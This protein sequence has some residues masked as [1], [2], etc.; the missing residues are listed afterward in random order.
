[1][2]EIVPSG[3]IGRYTPAKNPPYLSSG[4]HHMTFHADILRETRIMDSRKEDLLRAIDF[5]ERCFTAWEESGR[6]TPPQD[7]AIQ[8]HYLEWREALEKG[9]ANVK[10]LPAERPDESKTSPIREWRYRYFLSREVQKHVAAGRLGLR[11]GDQCMSE[12]AARIRALKATLQGSGLWQGVAK[13][14]NE[15]RQRAKAEEA[16]AEA[17]A[18][19]KPTPPPI[20]KKI[21]EPKEPR[22]SPLEVLL[23]PKSTQYLMMLGGGLAVLGLVIWL[24]VAGILENPLVASALMGVANLAV[25]GGGAAL[26]L[27]TRYQT[28][29]RG[30]T[31]LACLVLPLHLWFYSAQDLIPLSDGGP[32]WIPA[33][34]IC[35]LYA[36]TAYVVKDSSFVYVF[37]GG[38]T[39]T[40]L[41]ILADENVSRFGEVTAPA[42]LL[43]VIALA[44][45]HAER[46]FAP[47][48]GP[49]SREKFGSAF[50]YAGHA[51]LGAALMLLAGSQIAGWL[52][53][54][55]FVHL[56][57]FPEPAVMTELTFK[58]AFLGTVAA[59]T[60]A[61]IYSDL[62]V[63]RHHGFAY[64]AV[65]TLLWCEVLLVDILPIPLTEEVVIMILAITAL[66]A[67]G[68]LGLIIRDKKEEADS[69]AGL[70]EGW[71]VRMSQIASSLGLLLAV[72]PVSL[73]ILMYLRATFT[74]INEAWPNGPHE[75]GW[76]YVIAMALTAVSCRVGAQV[77]RYRQE[78]LTAVYFFGTAAATLMM[79]VGLFA[80]CGV[81][82]WDV[83]VPVLMLIPIAYLIAAKFWGE[84]IR[85]PLRRTAHIATGVMLAIVIGA[86]LNLTPDRRFAPIM[87][88]G[89]NLLV[90]LFFAEAVVFYVIAAMQSKRPVNAYMA[91]ICGAASIWQLLLYVNAPDVGYVATFAAIGL[92][93]LIAYRMA[94]TE[95]FAGANASLTAFRCGN[96]LLTC[97]GIGG[98][99]L[100]LGRFPSD[101]VDGTL[102]G[103][104]AFLTV[105]SVSAIFLVAHEGWRRTY[106]VLAIIQGLMTFL[107]FNAVSDLALWQEIEL[108]LLAVGLLLLGVGHFGWSRET[109]VRK[110][111]V[112]VALAL[113]SFLV[114]IPLVFGLIA[115]RCGIATFGGNWI[116]L[117]EIGALVAGLAL[118][119]SGIMCKIR[120][121]TFAGA[122][123]MLIY[124]PTLLCFVNFPGQLKSA[125]VYMIVG[126]CVLFTAAILL[127]V[128]RDRILALPDK[129]K[130][131]EGMFKVLQWR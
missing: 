112:T 35:I 30:V 93:I 126:G 11:T 107:V 48:E 31:L 124:I 117:H 16:A 118:I 20:P 39:L 104:T 81:R 18:V 99:L 45:I 80:A 90:A 19:T 40:G 51:L 32:L 53:E 127:S 122:L 83:T 121:T 75:L 123:A 89:T 17:A 120:S 61:Y 6:I 67:N 94:L 73:G 64:V 44:S 111:E 125:A 25:L 72:I 50:F 70:D 22:R 49:F 98:V 106:I 26:I 96:T 21:K 47:G 5:A 59:A 97:A 84:P 85:S 115:Y 76:S 102:L 54:A 9:E 87:G 65:V 71:V 7:A 58:L 108:F 105:A 129:I 100:A 109:E 36:A 103:L 38:I 2:T 56:D 78:K 119:G 101:S 52:Y 68:M 10:H 91:S 63:R 8:G 55:I 62:I 43:A 77:F 114:V 4:G 60:Y 13:D 66:L 113:G 34:I 33:L 37:V 131:Q 46:A 28:A 79:V 23:D 116:I 27:K 29:G 3:P 88:E 128:Y 57:M 92:A 69:L 86:V 1:M 14:L 42:V 74:A 24:V 110:D 130:N 12:T 15:N 82:S 95:K 41:L